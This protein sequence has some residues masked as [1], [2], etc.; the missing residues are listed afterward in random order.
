MT[1]KIENAAKKMSDLEFILHERFLAEGNNL[2]LHRRWINA[3]AELS[4][5]LAVA[6]AAKNHLVKQKEKA[7]WLQN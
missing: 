2:S 3:S 5:L 7:K 1:S 6:E 4:S